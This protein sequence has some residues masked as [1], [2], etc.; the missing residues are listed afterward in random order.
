MDPRQNGRPHTRRYR[1][2]DPQ[3]RENTF[4]HNSWGVCL[5]CIDGLQSFTLELETVNTKKNELDNIIAR[6]RRWIF[7]MRDGAFMIPDTGYKK[8]TEWKGIDRFYAREPR[9]QDKAP[10]PELTY[11]VVEIRWKRTM[12]D[13]AK[14]SHGEDWK[15]TTQG[16]MKIKPPPKNAPDE[17][18]GFGLFDR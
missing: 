2:E 9:D 7:P 14:D 10:P 1:P 6:S 5:L 4:E 8:V 13:P 3:R 11:Y 18:T 15:T 17:D 16:I 12:R